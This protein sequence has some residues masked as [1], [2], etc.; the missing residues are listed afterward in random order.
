MGDEQHEADDEKPAVILLPA[1]GVCGAAVVP[2]D[3]EDPVAGA[4][5]ASDL[6]RVRRRGRGAPTTD[7]HRS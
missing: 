1:G 3:P 7:D 2:V 6:R 5:A 4:E